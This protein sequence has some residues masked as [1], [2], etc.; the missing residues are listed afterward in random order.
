MD[1][2]TSA[3]DR[4]QYNLAFKYMFSHLPEGYSDLVFLIDKVGG[5]IKKVDNI[6]IF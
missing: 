5:L 2:I 6:E 1:G 3:P 4:A